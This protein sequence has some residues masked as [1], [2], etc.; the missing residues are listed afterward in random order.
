MAEQELVK[1]L[2]TEVHLRKT[3]GAGTVREGRR[4]CQAGELIKETSCPQT[5]E[6]NVKSWGLKTPFV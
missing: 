4:V 6:G 2:V 5:W 1:E 3:A